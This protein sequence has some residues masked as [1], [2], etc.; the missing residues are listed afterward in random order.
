MEN[1]NNNRETS[2]KSEIFSTLLF[3]L[4]VVVLSFLFVTFIG[5]RTTVS[6]ESMEN[7]LQD[8]DNL[9]IDKISYRLKDPE[10]FDII[11]FPPRIE[12]DT[13][14]IKRVIGLPGETVRIDEYGR[15]YI[16]GEIL[17]EDYGK[18]IIENPGR[19]IQPIT[20][21][22]DEYFV[23]GDNRNNSSDSR[24]EQ[25]GN[26]HRKEIVGKAFIRIYP[27]NNMGLIKHA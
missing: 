17:D 2:I 12:K 11:I 15:I 13:L 23:L 7:T 6:G 3:C 22:D 20:L 19:A 1:K 25:V 24:L 14:Y 8:R 4:C 27:F 18:E 5:Q 9:M 21:G 16:D 10:R 26:V